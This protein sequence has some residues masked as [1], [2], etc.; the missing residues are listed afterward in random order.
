MCNMNVFLTRV[1]GHECLTYH[2]HDNK[3]VNPTAF[4]P[5]INGTSY[6]RTEKRNQKNGNN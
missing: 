6:E 3:I 5:Y 2:H 4:F 1:Y